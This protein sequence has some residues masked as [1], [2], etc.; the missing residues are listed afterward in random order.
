MK[1]MGFYFFFAYFMV[2]SD[3]MK[4]D[5][6]CHSR[7]SYDGNSNPIDV[8]NSAKK[9]GLDGIA[10]TEH[11]NTDS[12]ADYRIA[13]QRTGIKLIFGQEIKTRQG[14]ILAYFITSPL[15]KGKDAKTTIEEIHKQGGVAIIAHPFH[16]FEGFKG[17]LQEYVEIIDGIEV[18]NAR[19]PFATANKLAIDFAQKNNLSHIAGSDAHLS[20]P[21][22]DAF[23]EV[24]GAHDLQD[25]KN[26]ILKK[27][28]VAIG[29]TSNYLYL[30]G[31]M[32]GKI[33]HLF[34]K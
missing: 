8:L 6:H 2:L 31:P 13:S 10:I 5:M 23:T 30:F 12:W 7:Y 19:C 33:K 26:A 22:G 27:E 29:K 25:F 14:D 20:Y 21:I 34:K 16:P 28:C 1:Y 17:N 9:K 32:I 3:K 24:K 11:N 15:Q 18:F 4:I